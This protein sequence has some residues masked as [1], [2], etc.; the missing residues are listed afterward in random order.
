MGVR[1]P[2]SAPSHLPDREAARPQAATRRVHR[3]ARV[4]WTLAGVAIAGL[5]FAVP[6]TTD[7]WEAQGEWTWLVVYLQEL[8]VATGVAVVGLVFALLLRRRWAARCLGQGMLAG[9]AGVGAAAALAFALLVGW[10]W[11]LPLL[12]PFAALLLG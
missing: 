6:F 2:A 10:P 9:L 8:W 7:S 12:S 1:H 11:M 5:S 3:G 4:A